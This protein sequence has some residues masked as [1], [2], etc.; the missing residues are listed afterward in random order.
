MVSEYIQLEADFPSSM[1]SLP[2]STPSGPG[3]PTLQL[4]PQLALVISQ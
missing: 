1:A 3:Q 4:T 2:P